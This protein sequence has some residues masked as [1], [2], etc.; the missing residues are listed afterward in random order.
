M[1][2]ED[3]GHYTPEQ[4]AEIIASYPEHEREA[5]AK[6]IPQ[7]GSGRVFPIA[8]SQ[9]SCEQIEIPKLWAVIGG[10]DFG[11]DHPF[12]AVK[13]A[14]DREADVVY[15]THAYRAREQTPIIHSAALKKWGDFP[16]AWPHDGMQHD[17][18]SGDRLAA[19]YGEQGLRMHHERATFAE[20]GNGVEA[21]IAEMLDRMKSGRLKVFKHLEDWFGEYRMYH[22]KDGVIVK[23]RDDLLSATRYGLMMLRFAEVPQP[24]VSL[25]VH[26]LPAFA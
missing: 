23:E 18:G 6:G 10:M 16:W 19:L 1:G 26:D 13:L 25:D 20:G 5:R 3:V 4:R 7:L 24:A 11:W 8:E 14:H 21:G 12:A 17:K 15:V 22:R 2:L 9:I